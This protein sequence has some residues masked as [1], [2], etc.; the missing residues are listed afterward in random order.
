MRLV[1]SGTLTPEELGRLADALL[2]AEGAAA[3]C[4][5]RVTDLTGLTRFEVGFDDM[6]QMARRRRERPPANPIR[7]AVVAS[8]PVQLGFARMFQTLNDHPQVTLRIFPDLDAALAW[9]KGDGP[10]A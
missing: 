5:P 10:E 1:L 3:V 7:S 2:E 6:F 9:A 4:P 8:T